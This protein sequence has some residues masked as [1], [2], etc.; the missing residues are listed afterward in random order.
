MKNDPKR[1]LLVRN[2]M[3]AAVFEHELK[4]Q[5]SDGQWEN[6]TVP[7]KDWWWITVKIAGPRDPIG[8]NF[9]PKYDKFNFAAKDLLSVVGNRMLAYARAAKA[10]VAF[11]DCAVMDY[12]VKTSFDLGKPIDD[13]FD[14]NLIFT[15]K[16]QMYA[17][18]RVAP[19]LKKYGEEFLKKALEDK[20]YGPKELVA[21]LKDLKSIARTLV[22]Y[23]PEVA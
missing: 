2:A 20:S 13:D 11:D 23:E 8:R 5:L 19:V 21:D 1:V 15:D 10:G 22:T 9:Y 6:A 3:Q 18:E 17:V 12:L 4:G 14:G 7:T 16:V